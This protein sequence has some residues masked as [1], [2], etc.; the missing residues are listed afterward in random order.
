MYTRR[1]SGKIIKDLNEANK[2]DAHLDHIQGKVQDE[3]RAIKTR[4][5]EFQH[6][7]LH[8]GQK[9]HICINQ[10]PKMKLLKL[11]LPNQKMNLPSKKESR[12]ESMEPTINMQVTKITD[13]Y[14]IIDWE[15]SESKGSQFFVNMIWFCPT[16]KHDWVLP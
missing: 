13:E 6:Y 15:I 2:S 14:A 16:T 8:Q 5:Q 11:M 3:S 12:D 4:V 10:T 1:L 7:Q 9:H